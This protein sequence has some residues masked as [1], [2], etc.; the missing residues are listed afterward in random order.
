M[1]AY[2]GAHFYAL[3][4]TPHPQ[5]A[6]LCLQALHEKRKKDI[7]YLI[8]EKIKKITKEVLISNGIDFEDEQHSEDL[9]LNADVVMKTLVFGESNN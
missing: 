3:S 2:F 8:L 7:L 9:I 4:C 1:H 6:L 5:S